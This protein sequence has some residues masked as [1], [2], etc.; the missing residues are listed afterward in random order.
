MNTLTIAVLLI[1]SVCALRGLTEGF[2]KTT[3]RLVLN[4][5]V[6]AI[7]IFITPILLRI[8]FANFLMNGM[9]AV[10]QL[11]VL[12][13]IFAL[14]RFGAKIIVASLNIIA[15]LP[16]LKT[17]NRLLGVVAGFLQGVA[18]VWA[19]FMVAMIFVETEFGQWVYTMCME[20]PYLTMLYQNNPII[21]IVEKYF[22][23]IL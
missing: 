14:L 4:L 15:K 12:V 3:F 20:N 22:F 11:L 18:V 1:I 17:L 21:Y 6:F 10:S 19:F 13:I 8:I 16:V 2:I 5:V 23:K 7:S 9:E